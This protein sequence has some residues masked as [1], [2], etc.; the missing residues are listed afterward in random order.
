MYDGNAK[1]NFETDTSR[2]ELSIC[3]GDAVG[4]IEDLGS[5]ASAHS[6]PRTHASSDISGIHT[7]RSESG[8]GCLTVG[9]GR[10][11]DAG[12]VENDP[13]PTAV[14]SA[15]P[16]LLVGVGTP[17]PSK[18]SS[19]SS[20]SDDDSSSTSSD[21]DVGVDKPIDGGEPTVADTL[22][23]LDEM[24]GRESGRELHTPY[25]KISFYC[26]RKNYFFVGHCGNDCHK[27][28]R[29]CRRTMSAMSSG[30]RGREGQGRPLGCIIAWLRNAYEDHASYGDREH[31]GYEPDFEF[32]VQCRAL[33][34]TIPG[35]LDFA[36]ACERPQRLGESNEPLTLPPIKAPR[37]R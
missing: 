27:G 31:I 29:G 8:G 17:G 15:E 20:S 3:D 16:A 23:I 7:P 37:A 9:V 1:R 25:G 34:E 22:A 2:C 18:P 14:V 30:Q 4:G 6:S 21:S 19:S 26:S 24:S 32:R 10:E 5:D 11:I 36:R 33:L 28:D 12:G 13:L 35:G